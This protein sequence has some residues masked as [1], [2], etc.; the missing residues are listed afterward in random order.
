M[1]R[2]VA[3]LATG[4]GVAW[5]G[6]QPEPLPSVFTSLPDAAETGMTFETWRAWFTDAA[7]RTIAA[8]DPYGVAVFYQTDRRHDGRIESKASLIMAA[9]EAAGARPLW[10]KIAVRRMSVDLF[11]PAYTHLIA[12]SPR[13]NA[14]RPTP[15]VFMQGAK[16]YKNATDAASLGVALG[17]I[18]REGIGAVADPFCGRGSIA[19]AAAVAGMGSW[20]VDIDPG[21]VAAARDL[22]APYA[23]IIEEGGEA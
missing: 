12:V 3:H 22:L 4:D 19:R 16:V 1:S 11:R 8:T 6:R 10:H 23:D 5:L 2:P 18:D 13:R 9:A 17:F 20:S 7:A 14:G 21:Q 15:D